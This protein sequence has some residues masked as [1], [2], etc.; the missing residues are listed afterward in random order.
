[1]DEELAAQTCSDMYNGTLASAQTRSVNNFLVN[2]MVQK[3]GEDA[4]SLFRNSHGSLFR[5][6][7]S[8]GVRRGFKSQKHRWWWQKEHPTFLLSGEVFL[9]T[10][11]QTPSP[12]TRIINNVGMESKQISLLVLCLKFPLCEC[13][14]CIPDNRGAL[15]AQEEIKSDA[16][17]CHCHNFSG[18]P[19]HDSRSR[20]QK[21]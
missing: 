10:R 19:T 13:G 3:G 7:D 5:I 2:W 16:L 9:L 18:I 11:E 20:N 1:M 4:L 12:R 6:L 14:F 17:F 8:L 21:C 15:D